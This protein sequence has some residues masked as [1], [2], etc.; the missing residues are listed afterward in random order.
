MKR[1]FE[2][3]LLRRRFKKH[4]KTSLFAIFV[5]ALLPGQVFAQAQCNAQMNAEALGG[6]LQYINEPITIELTMGA[7]TVVEIDG[8]T[9]GYLDIFNFTYDMDCEYDPNNPATWPN[10]TPTGN[11]VEFVPGT[12]TTDCTNAEVGGDVVTLATQVVEEQILFSVDPATPDP[13]AIR[14]SSGETCQ[15]QFDIVVTSIAGDNLEREIYELTG[16]AGTGGDAEC[17]NGLP[18]GAG[19]SV[20]FDLSTV[21]TNFWVTKDF[22]DDNPDPVNVNIKCF[23]GLPLEQSFMITEDTTV[24]FVVKSYVAGELDCEIWEEPIPGGYTP[25]YLAGATTGVTADTGGVS[26]DADGCY[27]D[28]VINGSFTC[29]ITNNADPAT[30]TVTKRWEYF[31]STEEDLYGDVPVSI[32]CDNEILIQGAIFDPSSGYWSLSGF[33][34]DGESLTAMVDTSA[35]SANCMASETATESLFESSDDCDSRTIPAGGSS[36]CTITNSLFFEGIPTL[37]Q[38]GLVLMALLM[39]GMGMVGV[40]RL[41]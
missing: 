31:N 13:D 23:T 28:D 8:M 35:D 41:S 1:S 18:A 38:Y 3:S 40:R 7:G 2:S 9:P 4:N 27:Y 30:F 5:A 19:S 22:S 36:E 21:V 34:G 12:V 10:C 14:N 39:L 17:S 6:P 33:L 25:D 16:I 24:G 32:F 26:E 37:S 15:V 11:T 29:A 20:L